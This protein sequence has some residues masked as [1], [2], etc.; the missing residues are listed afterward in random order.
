VGI[1]PPAEA[2]ALSI[3]GRE[4]MVADVRAMGIAAEIAQDMG[5]AAEGGLVIDEPPLF[6]QLLHQFLK[7]RGVAEIGGRT[8]AVEQVPAVEL[9]E[10]QEEL[11]AK[12]GA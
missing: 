4:A 7:P 11:L 1:I 10:S 8:W 9:A 5:G 12:H 2:D 6:A 3:E